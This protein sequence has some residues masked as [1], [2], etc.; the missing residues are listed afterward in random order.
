MGGFVGGV[1]GG[2]G[3]GGGEGSDA[4]TSSPPGAIEC[5]SVSDDGRQVLTAGVDGCFTLWLVA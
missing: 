5:L 1:G 2:G 4:D 3:G